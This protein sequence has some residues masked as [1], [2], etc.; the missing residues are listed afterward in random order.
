MRSSRV[1]VSVAIASEMTGNIIV[2]IF[3]V[4][5]TNVIWTSVSIYNC[6]PYRDN[7]LLSSQAAR[8]RYLCPGAGIIP[9]LAASLPEEPSI[10][11][12]AVSKTKKQTALLPP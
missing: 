6:H 3:D 1:L 2:G 12:Q 7:V 10:D 5:S 8:H 4:D 9:A 11:A